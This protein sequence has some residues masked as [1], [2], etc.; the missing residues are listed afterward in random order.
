MFRRTS[1]AVAAVAGLSLVLAGCGGSDDATTTA[2]AKPTFAAGST[3][4]AL[5]AKGTLTVGTKFDQPGFGLQGL[6]GAPSGFDVEVAKLVAAGLGIPADKITW[7]ETPSKVREEVIEQGK[8]DYVVATYTINAKRKERISFAGPYYTAGQDIMVAKDDTTI[9]GPDSLKTNPTAK[10]CS[11]TGSTPAEKIK[12][13]L[14][15]PDQLVLFDVYSKCADALR[16]GQVKAVT[17]D[18]VILLGLV[19]TAKGAF[20]L[21]G[22]AFT[23]E[24]YGIGIKKGDAAFCTFINDVL[25][26]ASASGAY[27]KAWK[28]TAGKVEG[29][30][31][32]DLPALGSCS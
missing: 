13:Y 30:Q 21:V 27:A 19:S 1:A 16:T 4:A 29:A 18:N 10:I 23:E 17:T 14:A 2:A 8:V 31:T 20:K 3:M 24:P 7:T 15:A 22:N 11:V 25:T 28:D 9:T 5:A 32:P 12:T 26:K 6:D